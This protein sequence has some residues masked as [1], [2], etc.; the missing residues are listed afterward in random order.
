MPLNI[1]FDTKTQ[2]EPRWPDLNVIDSIHFK[3]ADFSSTALHIITL[4]A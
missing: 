2:K 3:I 1:Y 4:N